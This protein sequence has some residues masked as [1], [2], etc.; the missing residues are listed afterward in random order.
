MWEFFK[1]IGS[2]PKN[3]VRVKSRTGFEFVLPIVISNPAA[4]LPSEKWITDNKDKFLAV[5]L[6]EETISPT[7]VLIGFY[8]VAGAS[9]TEFN[10]F[11]QLLKACTELTQALQEAKVATSIGPQPFMPDTLTKLGDLKTNL[12]KIKESINSIT[13]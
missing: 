4:P 3:T 7:P 10:I 11:E 2:E 8:P 13:I 1:I 9:S 5:I 6:T 12:D